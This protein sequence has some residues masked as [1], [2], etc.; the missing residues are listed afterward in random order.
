[1]NDLTSSPPSPSERVM[2][3]RAARWVQLLVGIICMSMI[4]NLQYGWTLFVT[5]IDDK[6]HWGR[7]AIQVAFTLFVL[8]ETWLIP[9]EGYLVD[10]FGPRWVVLGGSFLVAMA[11][12]INSVAAS[13]PVLYL[14]AAIGGIGTGCV[15][16]RCVGNA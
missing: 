4:A 2:P 14:A 12:V 8:V 3:P 11:W 10:R 5:P 16:G 9:V 7:A 6:F 15:Y 13:L 1:M